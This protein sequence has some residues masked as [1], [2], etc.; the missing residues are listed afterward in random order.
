MLYPAELQTHIHMKY[1]YILLDKESYVNTE[2]SQIP[3]SK[4]FLLGWKSAIIHP[5]EKEMC[6]MPYKG[7]VEGKVAPRNCMIRCPQ[8]G[9]WLDVLVTAVPD[10]GNILV[11]NVRCECGCLLHAG[12][13]EKD[14]WM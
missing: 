7:F 10:K 11:E 2:R 5:K 12:S 14:Y 9:I 13:N 3:E 4:P 8:C 1:C 6:L